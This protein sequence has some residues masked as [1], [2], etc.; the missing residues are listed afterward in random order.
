MGDLTPY[1]FCAYGLLGKGSQPVSPR[2]PLPSTLS[3][4]TKSCPP[5][6]PPGPHS[7][8]ARGGG[9][10]RGTRRPESRAENKLGS[11]LAL[12]TLLGSGTTTQQVIPCKRAFLST[13]PQTIKPQRDDWDSSPC[14]SSPPGGQGA[15]GRDID[16]S[17]IHAYIHVCHMTVAYIPPYSEL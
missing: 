5:G 8:Q 13:S 3:S 11:A 4:L 2:A 7:A 12:K 15:P 1:T 9:G 14:L 17:D 16:D 6:H 10:G